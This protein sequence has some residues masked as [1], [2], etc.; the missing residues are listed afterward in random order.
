MISGQMNMMNDGIRL[1]S[2]TALFYIRSV[3]CWATVLQSSAPTITEHTVSTELNQ[4]VKI[5]KTSTNWPYSRWWKQAGT[6]F[7]SSNSG[8]QC[9][10]LCPWEIIYKKKW[11]NNKNLIEKR[12]KVNTEFKNQ[13]YFEQIKSKL[14]C[15]CRQ[16][17]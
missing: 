7:F 5:F 14:H 15:H 8:K 4:L 12:K 16:L 17:I 10:M 9:R 13:S 1:T 2:N 11:Y 3:Q 6:Q